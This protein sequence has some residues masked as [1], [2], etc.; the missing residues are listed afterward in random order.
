MADIIPEIGQWLTVNTDMPWCSTPG[1]VVSVDLDK[2]TF[3]AEFVCDPDQGEYPSF[4][5]AT[6]HEFHAINEIIRNPKMIEDFEIWHR[7][8]NG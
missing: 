4:E 3:Q 6:T 7:E 5:A 2:K 8:S 1:K